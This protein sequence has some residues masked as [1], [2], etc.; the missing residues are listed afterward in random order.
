MDLLART[1][2]SAANKDKKQH[3]YSRRHFFSWFLDNSDPAADDIA[4][5]SG[6]SFAWNEVQSDPYE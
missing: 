6:C 1:N 5:V 3:D 2:A 4:E